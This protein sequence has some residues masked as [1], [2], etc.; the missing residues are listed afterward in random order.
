M[1]LLEQDEKDLLLELLHA[2]DKSNSG[3]LF[4]DFVLRKDKVPLAVII[5]N[6]NDY[7]NQ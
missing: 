5:S 2:N 3:P 1:L 6:L 7:I 4:N